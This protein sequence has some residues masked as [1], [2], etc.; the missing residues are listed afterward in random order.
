M[1]LGPGPD[2]GNAHLLP[3]H[4]GPFLL[5]RLVLPLM[6]PHG[7]VVTV[8]SEAHRRAAPRGSGSLTGPSSGNW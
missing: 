8:G 7:R 2:G 5:T 1:G 6:A 3:N 4:L